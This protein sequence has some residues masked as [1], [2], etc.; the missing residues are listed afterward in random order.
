MVLLPGCSC[1]TSQETNCV[2]GVPAGYSY[3]VSTG[4]T[5]VC[6]GVTWN[7]ASTTYFGTRSLWADNRWDYLADR[8]LFASLYPGRQGL[9]CIDSA[10]SSVFC[11]FE[12]GTYQGI[13]ANKTR[14]RAF[15]KFCDPP[16]WEDIS[17][18]VITVPFGYGISR[19]CRP[20]NGF[21]QCTNT[22]P[23]CDDIPFPEPLNPAIACA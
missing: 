1:C 19:D 9:I 11:S 14:H 20:L 10:T 21:G 23:P 2:C 8:A 3:S 13:S 16:R 6:S 17:D 5:E 18:E 22:D 12:C 4:G 15:V 7:M